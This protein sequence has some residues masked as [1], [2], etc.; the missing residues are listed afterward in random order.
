MT[1]KPTEYFVKG[2][3]LDGRDLDELRNIEIT[4]HVLNGCDGS[5]LIKWGNNL[6]LA[7]VRG[8]RDCIPKHLSDPFQARL[9]VKYNMTPFSSMNEHGR[10][11]PSRRSIELSKIIRNAFEDVVILDKF[12]KA[13]IEIFIEILQSDGGTRCAAMTAASV[14]LADAGIPMKDMVQ[15]VAAGKVDGKIILDMNYIEDAANGGA[16]VPIA[17]AGRN[18]QVLAFQMDG[19]LNKEDF[20][21]MFEMVEKASVIIKQKQIEALEKVYFSEEGKE[22]EKRLPL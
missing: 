15:A 20:E 1:D 2:K 10:S 17:I 6:I 4:A 21:Q 18:K 5:A 11:G 19:I 16:D 13:Q 9:K 12:P 14:A 7:G 3:R 22:T 8:P